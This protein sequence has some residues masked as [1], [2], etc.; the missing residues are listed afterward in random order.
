MRNELIGHTGAGS[1]ARTPIGQHGAPEDVK[2]VLGGRVLGGDGKR[3]PR[4]RGGR[5][6]DEF[7]NRR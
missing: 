2:H 4:P 5:S 6:P 7:D 3:R 1:V